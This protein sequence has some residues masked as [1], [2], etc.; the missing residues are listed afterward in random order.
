MTIYENTQYKGLNAAIY[1]CDLLPTK[2]NIDGQISATKRIKGRSGNPSYTRL[3]GLDESYAINT[4][5]IK[6]Q[7]K[8]YKSAFGK[9]L[10]PKICK[11]KEDLSLQLDNLHDRLLLKA[12]AAQVAK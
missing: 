5:E 7:K 6:E 1:Y 8:L 3:E 9:S 4:M 10:N 12:F 11:K 2:I